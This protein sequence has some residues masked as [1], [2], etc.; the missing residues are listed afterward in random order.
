MG[1][2]QANIKNSTEEEFKKFDL[3]T[4]PNFEAAYPVDI[5][6]T[7][8]FTDSADR[9]QSDIEARDVASIKNFRVRYGS[10]LP[11]G[12]KLKLTDIYFEKTYSSLIAK[13]QGRI[14]ALLK[15]IE[16]SSDA[17][18]KIDNVDTARIKAVDITSKTLL[19]ANQIEFPIQLKPDLPITVETLDLDKAIT[20]DAGA[21]TEILVLIDIAAA[22]VNR[23][24]HAYEPVSSEHQVGTESYQNPS[25]TTAQ[26][27]L[28]QAQ[29]TLQAANMSQMRADSTYC[30][31]YGCLG[32]ALAQIAAA[33]EI[34]EAQDVLKSA[35]SEMQSTPM[36]LERPVY[37]SY[38]FRKASID[39]SKLA[40]VNYYIINK[41]AGKYVKGTF[42]AKQ[43]QSFAVPYNMKLTDR[44]KS[45]HLSGLD[46]EKDI[47]RFE[48]KPFSISLTR[49]LQEYNETKE[50]LTNLVSLPDLRT[51]ILRDKNIVLARF[52]AD[53]ITASNTSMH[54]ELSKSV[55]VVHNLN[56]SLGSGFYVNDDVV[57]TNYHVVEDSSFVEMTLKD[58]T[59]T[60]GK[61]IAKD[62][63]L[64]LALIRTQHRGTPVKFN[65]GNDIEIGATTFA[66][67][68][69]R[70][71][72]FSVTRGIVSAIRS[73]KNVI[74]NQGKNVYFIQTD[75][76]LNS[77]N[78]GGPLFL[79]GQV[80]G[81]NDFVISKKIAEGLNFA[82]HVKEVLKFLK[83]QNV[84][85]NVVGS[86][87]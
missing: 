8:L 83:K 85:V 54:A 39:A 4:D 30:T 57:L 59:E 71:L 31:G 28:M 73:H 7:E 55:V 87:S 64:D 36:M 48:E 49:I 60:F 35:M 52:L 68:H 53:R 86:T 14:G 17:G 10:D 20:A 41:N 2:L 13:N 65:H 67:G 21:D 78:S 34:S 58:G 24:I 22:K 19:S 16:L 50:P 84:S 12:L 3:F 5:N 46:S 44:Y 47:E 23:E 43:E 62:V 25:Y 40:V 11:M 38:N 26:N 69:P 72:E 37:A 61:I 45:R 74:F 75:T 6:L 15:A 9:I 42:D 82:I 33:V 81:V 76:P 79:D 66:I 32:K 29:M 27:S 70:G 56:G 18:F 80:I 63:R 51:R 1:A 77:G